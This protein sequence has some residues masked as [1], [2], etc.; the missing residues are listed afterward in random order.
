MKKE[1]VIIELKHPETEHV[2]TVDAPHKIKMG[3]FETFIEVRAGLPPIHNV[4]PFD[5]K[6]L[7]QQVIVFLLIIG[8]G[9]MTYNEYTESV[10]GFAIFIGLE[11]FALLYYLTR[12]YFKIFIRSCLKKGYILENEEHVELLKSAG[13]LFHYST[14]KKVSA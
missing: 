14:D 2:I 3:I 12:N 1:R 10:N 13:V 6:G 9:S 11:L 4:K 7:A 5:K 8:I